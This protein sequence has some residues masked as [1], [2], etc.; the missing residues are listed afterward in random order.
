M[1]TPSPA[2]LIGRRG[3]HGGRIALTIAL[4]LLPVA[5]ASAQTAVASLSGRVTDPQS[6]AV[7]GAQVTLRNGDTG[8]TLTAVTDTAGRYAVPMVPPGTYELTV[9]STGFASW[10]GAAIGLQVG[11]DHQ[12]DV[13]LSLAAVQESLVVREAARIVTTAVDGVIAAPQIQSMPLNGR[14]FLEL[15]LLVPGNQ[16]A[17]TFDPT[18]TNSML[19]SSAGQMGR[20]G[21]ITIDGQDN[22]DDVVGGPLLNLPIDAVQEFQIATNRF[23]ADQGRSA[24]SVIN[25]VTRSGSNTLHG[26][27]S[28]Y[29]RDD[30]WQARPVTVAATFEVPPFDRQQIS[31]AVGGPLRTDRAFWFGAAEYRN[32]DGAVLT[33]ARDTATRTITR[34]FAAAPLDDALWLLRLDVGA[35]ASRFTARYAGED[36]S[37]TAASAVDRAIGSAT[38]RQRASNAYHALLGSW[39]AVASP[40]MVNALNVSLSTFR[41]TTVPVAELPQLTFPSLQDGASFRMPQE[42]TQRRLQVSDNLSLVRGAHTVRVGGQLERI[43]ARFVLGVFQQGRVELVEDFPSFDHNGDGRIDDADL[44]FS[45]TLRSGNPTQAL[46]LPNSDNTHV[47]AFVH[48]DWNVGERLTVNAGLRYEVDTEVNNQGRARRAEPDRGPVC[49][50]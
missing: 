48:D 38:Q 11:Q 32:Q 40:T 10:R 29:A 41:N 37:D 16:P 43:D 25:I 45:V 35:A 50:R 19:V 15:A 28:L 36:A 13:P 47:A 24:S 7:A 33:G 44:L 6:S 20:G 30:A 1:T 31:G 22:N 23:A 26:S 21:N 12:L 2:N 5:T 42:T 8:T 34:G 46:D 49:R 3:R 27:A 14:N 18:K 4:L 9:D 39:T 17:P